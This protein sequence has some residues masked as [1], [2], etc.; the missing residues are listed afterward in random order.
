MILRPER[1]GPEEARPMQDEHESTPAVIPPTGVPVVLLRWTLILSLAFLMSTLAGPQS[2]LS[3]G[4][5]ALGIFCATNVLLTAFDFVLGSWKRLAPALVGLDAVLVAMIIGAC[6]PHATELF[7][8]YAGIAALVALG[9]S[10]QRIV[11][12]AVV[13]TAAAWMLALPQAG[14]NGVTEVATGLPAAGAEIGFGACLALYAG[15][16]TL[17]ARRRRRADQLVER[18]NRELHTLLDILETVTSSLDLH[19]VMRTI[20][21]RV[22][23]IVE[24]D[25]ASLLLLDREPELGWVIASSESS[26]V[27]M[28]PLDLRKY[29][30]VQQA[31]ATNSTVVV[32]DAGRSPLMSPVHEQIRRVRADAL[33]VIPL[34]FQEE[35][36]GALLLRGKRGRK[37]FGPEEVRFCQLVASASVSALKNAMLYREVRLESEQHRSTSEKLGQ[38]LENSM[39]VI[40][41]VDPEGKITEFNPSA[42]SV[43]GWSREQMMGKPLSDLLEGAPGE[44]APNGSPDLLAR[45]RRAGRVVEE[46]TPVRR[47]DGNPVELDLTFTTVRN[48]LGEMVGAVC[49]GTDPS[50]LH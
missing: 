36:L 2:F 13:L 4:G 31:I 20:V 39:Q 6:E 33:L 17:T 19:R 12:A 38:I 37:S 26:A 42:E 48:D 9:D 7:V 40:V 47:G 25:R 3:A 29:P 28:L 41:T 30:E 16:V 44:G 11:S 27:D 32:D 49:L 23:E 18:E 22:G 5:F 24:V 14:L 35:M 46:G 1:P 45:L 21:A 10:V 50:R 43:L 15:T 34:I 8:L